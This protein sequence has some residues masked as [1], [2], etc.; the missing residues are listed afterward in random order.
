ML[1]DKVIVVSGGAGLLGLEFCKS[2][3]TNGATVV[4]ADVAQEIAES[5]AEKI[6]SEFASVSVAAITMDITQKTSVVNAI[7]FLASKYGKIDAIVNNAYPRNK[8]YGRKLEQVQY[9]DYCENVGMHLGGYF[10]TTQQFAMYFAKQG[11]GNVI[12]IS[13]IYGVI[14]PKFDIYNGTEMTMPIEYAAIKSALIHTT[15]Y[16]SQY[17]KGRGLRF[18]CI[19]PGGI[20]N[21]QAELFI[22]QYNEKCNSK[23]MLDPAD[24]VGS[25]L[26]LLSDHSQ[27]ING[28]NLV[29]D[30]GF[31]L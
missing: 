7:E 13:S 16:F 22:Q 4:I 30:D 27:Y 2:I 3:A 12:N 10:L 20:F 21:Q 15:K 24:I 9:A 11:F 6:L 17:Y 23:G 29:I 28:Q 14:P 19:S 25:L 8:N 1:N 5:A 31:T 26:F 18:N